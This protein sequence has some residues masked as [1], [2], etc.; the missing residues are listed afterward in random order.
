MKNNSVYA[1][2]EAYDRIF[3]ALG[4]PHRLQIIGSQAMVGESGLE[5][6]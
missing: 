5:T 2:G 4:D 1:G 3:R 6:C